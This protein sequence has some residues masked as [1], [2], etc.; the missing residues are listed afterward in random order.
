MAQEISSASFCVTPHLVRSYTRAF[1]LETGETNISDIYTLIL[2][3]DVS[4]LSRIRKV[5]CG[6]NCSSIDWERMLVSIRGSHNDPLYIAG[7]N[8]SSVIDINLY[9][10][11]VDD[12]VQT[13][14]S[15]GSSHRLSV[16]IPGD[17]EERPETLLKSMVLDMPDGATCLSFSSAFDID[18]VEQRFRNGRFEETRK[19][20]PPGKHKTLLSGHRDSDYFGISINITL[21][22]HHDVEHKYVI[23]GRL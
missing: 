11:N 12:V 5:S 2:R 6:N 23:H 8:G 16:V 1:F 22:G 7:C 4:D 3:G 10:R 17:W 15:D 9:D 13:E 20:M 14:L 18:F 19:T 21:S